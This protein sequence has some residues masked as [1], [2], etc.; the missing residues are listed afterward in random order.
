MF[1]PFPP[2]LLHL[3]CSPFGTPPIDLV[4]LDIFCS[5]NY[6]L[7]W[8]A[9]PLPLRTPPPTF[10]L[11]PFRQPS[12]PAPTSLVQ[13]AVSP[14]FSVR[15]TGLL[16]LLP[17][18]IVYPLLPFSVLPLLVSRPG[19]SSFFFFPP[20]EALLIGLCLSSPWLITQLPSSLLPLRNR[21]S[22]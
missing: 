1:S 3:S 8:A 10:R 12:P 2:S 13:S 14:P 17:L 21:Y 20:I 15:I 16:L 9:F 5:L 18:F 4:V 7:N 22:S 19:R 6:I 11:S